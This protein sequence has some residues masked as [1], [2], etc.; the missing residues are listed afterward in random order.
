MPL[1]PDPSS[2]PPLPLL[3]PPLPLL[4]PVF[5]EP[6]PPEPEFAELL[7]PLLPEP[8]DD[9]PLPDCEPPDEVE[10]SPVAA[11]LNPRPTWSAPWDVQ[12]GPAPP[13]HPPYA[14]ASTIT[15]EFVA[16]AVD[17]AG[18]VCAPAIAA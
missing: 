15:P 10:P 2:P 3:A 7:P 5:P 11:T 12:P 13:A 8:V 4:F 18:F 6:S 14:C 17:P 1:F 16:C 9:G